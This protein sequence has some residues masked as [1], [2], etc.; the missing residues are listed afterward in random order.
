[1]ASLIFLRIMF[2]VSL[3]LLMPY[4]F[5][6]LYGVA[7]CLVHQFDAEF[8]DF[9]QLFVTACADLFF[10]YKGLRAVS[11]MDETLINKCSKYF[12]VC[13][14]LTVLSLIVTTCFDDE[15]MIAIM[16]DTVNLFL[17]LFSGISLFMLRIK[18][19]EIR[20]TSIIHN[21]NL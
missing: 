3:I 15:E 1:M 4:I 21:E 10:V 17:F 16:Y 7:G 2:I 19:Q 11:R 14:L 18:L 13:F 8:I 9:L 5:L 20:E 12:S 6:R